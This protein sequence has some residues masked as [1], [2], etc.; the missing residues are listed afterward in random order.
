MFTG[1]YITV[2]LI[3]FISGIILCI[4]GLKTYRFF[5]YICGIF[6]AFSMAEYLKI[7][8]LF[9][10]KGLNERELWFA[11][12]LCGFIIGF[13]F[14]KTYKISSYLAAV[15]ATFYIVN[16]Y[17]ALSSI[18][19]FIKTDVK[20]SLILSLILGS[21]FYFL[22]RRSFTI[23]LSSALGALLISSSL[24]IIQFISSVGFDKTLTYLQSIDKFPNGEYLYIFIKD[25][26]LNIM[27]GALPISI[28]VLAC[29]IQY[30]ITCRK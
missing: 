4:S 9:V 29:F 3:F 25:I 1:I 6:A 22:L 15:Y 11:I 12:L 13:L 28:T 27:T 23:F 18:L 5:L 26:D 24:N 21:V 8:I 17:S 14:Y 10:V 19:S 30:F 20:I 2:N 7:L 16:Y